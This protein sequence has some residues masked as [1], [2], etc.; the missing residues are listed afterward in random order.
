M[1]DD[2]ARVTLDALAAAQ[3]GE[4][5]AELQEL[6]ANSVAKSRAAFRDANA[7]ALE[8]A[9]LVEDAL[10]TAVAGAKTVGEKVLATTEAN[11]QAAFEAAQSLARAKTVPEALKI[12]AGYL[13]DQAGKVVAQAQDIFAL[14]SNVA[15]STLTAF[16]QAAE[17]GVQQ[18]RKVG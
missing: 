3:K 17:K 13:Q 7:V 12:Q 4:I 6:A 8:Q 5:P 18:L 16:S 2:L 15:Q 14:S 11:T 10:A 1:K 9:K